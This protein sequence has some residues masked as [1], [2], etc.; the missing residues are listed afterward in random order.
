[1]GHVIE[2]AA[3]EVN[4]APL[5]YDEAGSGHPL[6]LVHGGLGDRRMWDGQM[7]AFA[8]RY[9]VIRYDQHGYGA[10][11]V[12][13]SPV[14]FHE[15]L[16]G[17]LRVLGIPYAHVLGL[18]FGAGVVTDFVLTYPEMVSSF[19]SVTSVI[20]GISEETT[21]R[22]EEADHAGEA[23]DL[24]RAVELELRLWI[25]GVGRRPNEVDAQV[26]ERVRA[27]NRAVWETD[28]SD[29]E[30]VELYPSAQSRLSDIEAPTLVVV[31]QLDIPDVQATGEL[32]EREIR[33]ARRATI[34][35]AAHHP[36]MEQPA[37]FNEAVL[38]FLSTV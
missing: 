22:M 19:I 16:Y 18:S 13:A 6:V 25:D 4:G 24:D 30:I 35:H 2:T 17:F 15:D 1:M 10:S 5:A 7:E 9:R 36:Q 26:R 20:G 14:A 8:Q 3:V 31:G 28:N 11:P 33:G 37:M 12:P 27:M 32:L 29:V 23:G 21:A 38:E 34:P